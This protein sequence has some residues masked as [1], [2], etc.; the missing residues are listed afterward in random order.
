M[1]SVG[2]RMD[3]HGIENQVNNSHIV[4]GIR[5]S[6]SNRPPKQNDSTNHLKPSQSQS[7]GLTHPVKTGWYEGEVDVLGNRHGKGITKHDDGTEYEGLYV[8]DV[9]E[10]WGRYKFVTLRQ[11][12]SN[13]LFSHKSS[14]LHRHVERSFE[15]IFHN[16]KP[17]GVGKLLTKTTDFVP[18]ETSQG[19]DSSGV[20]I[21]FIE[22]VHD[23]GYHKDGRAIGEGVRFIFLKTEMKNC[24][25]ESCFRLVNGECSNLRVAHDY[26][27]WVCN[28]LGTDAPAPPAL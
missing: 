28:C 20:D 6:A 16:D 23:V 10:G 12:V 1:Q 3:F 5:I 18:Q 15:G 27:E 24:W 9:M 8:N 13:P 22:I 19:W 26:A 7:N 11:L 17:S 14:Q 4:K 25:D 21:K 2:V